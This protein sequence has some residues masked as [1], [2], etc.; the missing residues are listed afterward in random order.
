MTSTLVI[1]W[2]SELWD[3]YILLCEFKDVKQPRCSHNQQISVSNG[4]SV[5]L[6][7]GFS[8]HAM[9]VGNAC[10]QLWISVSGGISMPLR[11]GFSRW[12]CR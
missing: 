5:S 2:I 1:L 10:V 11:F 4:I 12:I 7:F 6:R 3:I 8:G 9:E